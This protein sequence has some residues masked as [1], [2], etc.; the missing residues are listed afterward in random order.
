MEAVKDLIQGDDNKAEARRETLSAADLQAMQYPSAII[1]WE[2]KHHIVRIERNGMIYVVC[3][4]FDA[5]NKQME[6][7]KAEYR[8][9]NLRRYVAEAQA[10]AYLGEQQAMDFSG[11]G[12]AVT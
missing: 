9:Q 7:E 12:G 2:L 11:K 10:A 4:D 3:T 8:R 6:E 1:E 5:F